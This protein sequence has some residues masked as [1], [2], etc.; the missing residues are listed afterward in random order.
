MTAATSPAVRSRSRKSRSEKPN[1]AIDI[2]KRIYAEL[3]ELE[4]SYARRGRSLEELGTADDLVERMVAILPDPSAWDDTLGPFYGSAKVATMLGGISRQALS[5]RRGRKSLLA[6]KT[7]DGAWIYP[8]FQF[9]R[10]NRVFPGLPALLKV[11]ESSGVDDWTAAGWVV[12]PLESLGG[13][14]AVEWLSRGL[15]RDVALEAARD[16]ARRFAQ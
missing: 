4:A 8:T 3:Q 9:D 16:A 14:S 15:D 12:S 7:A 10:N 2:S 11:L 5:E 13:L 6:L 1:L